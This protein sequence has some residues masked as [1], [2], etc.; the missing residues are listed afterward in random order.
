MK[1][2]GLDFFL[3]IDELYA[4]QALIGA[5][6]KE[7]E[8]AFNRATKRTQAT[9]RSRSL[10]ALREGMGAKSSR[11][12][13]RR[14]QS[15]RYAFRLGKTSGDFDALKLWFGLNDIS[16]GHLRGRVSRIGTKR[17]PRGAT[18]SS[19]MMGAHEFDMGFI[20]NRYSRRSI[21]VRKGLSRFPVKEARVSVHD[22]MQT[23]LEDEVLAELPDVFM[24]HYVTD[25]QGRVAARTTIKSRQRGWNKYGDRYGGY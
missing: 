22:K 8:A 21:F 14:M 1:D 5:T 2:L 16:V 12:I 25:L 13:K 19:A 11:I 3:D 17:E 15:F 20:A 7:V 24:S 9:M 18:F 6:P 10:K 23:H 4:A